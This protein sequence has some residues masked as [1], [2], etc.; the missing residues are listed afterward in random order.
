MPDT[1]LQQKRFP[2]FENS[3]LIEV[4]LG[5]QFATPQKY[6]QIYAGDV[7]KLFRDE[8]PK[9]QEHPP[10]EPIFELFGPE[11]RASS[12]KLNIITGA[13]HDRFWFLTQNE[14]QLLQ[15]QQDR[16]LHNWRKVGIAVSTYPRFESII[17]KFE[18]ELRRL[19]E[20]FSTLVPQT[21]ATQTL[22]IN[23]CDI[24]YIN[25][26]S[27]E[28]EEDA[29][30]SKW[31]RFVNFNTNDPDDFSL[32]FR[33][34]ILDDIEQKPQGRFSFEASSARSDGKPIIVIALTVRGTP[35]NGDIDS[36]LQFITK[37]RELIARRFIELTTERAHQ[38]WGMIK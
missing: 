22:A 36:A 11:D 12:G 18:Q 38:I 13:S 7:W 23:Q 5:A 20:F 4:V 15:F 19:E 21:L 10:L 37:G 26:V 3:P 33:E 2:E 32:K 30:A 17:V 1:H 16:L 34:V 24:T 28:R 25:H 9:V 6:E 8:F 14:D 35:Q 27:I 29:K 31:L